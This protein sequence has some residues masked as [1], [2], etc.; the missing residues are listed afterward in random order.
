[1]R[2]LSGRVVIGLAIVIVGVLTL[3]ARLGVGVDVRR[4]WDFWPVIP[5]IL[6][7][8]WLILSFSSGGEG[9]GRRFNFSCAQF[10][11]AAIVTA[12]GAVYL[13]RNLGLFTV[14]MSLF[15]SILWPVLLIFI[16][17]S[18]IRGRA[19]GG[20]GRTAIMGG[21]DLGKGQAAWKLESGSYLAFMGGIS[22]DLTTAEIPPGETVLDFTAFMGGIDLKVPPGLPLIYDG[23][24]VLGGVT[25]L[26]QE[27]GGIVTSRR[28]ESNVGTDDSRLV[29]I[30]ARAIMGGIEIKEK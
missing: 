18:L 6:G 24:A 22:M 23:Q 3:L 30:Q 11:T 7:L 5:L 20:R 2:F 10:I 19:A 14:D 9:E 12:I 8:N 26:G 17:F 21:I 13:G 1:M 27:D 16:G 25:F 15:W 29:R 4:V 28:M